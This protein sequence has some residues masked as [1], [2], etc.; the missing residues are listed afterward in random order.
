MESLDLLNVSKE[1]AVPM[2]CPASWICKAATSKLLTTESA[3]PATPPTPAVPSTSG[4]LGYP[5]IGSV[6]D[7]DPHV[8]RP[9]DPDP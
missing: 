4:E 8:F 1:S 5:N 9:L 6:S 3:S 2:E 7:P